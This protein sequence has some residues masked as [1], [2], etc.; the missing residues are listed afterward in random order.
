M[1]QTK[2]T[3]DE[4]DHL[5]KEELLHRMQARYAKH[6]KNCRIHAIV[7]MACLLLLVFLC[8]FGHLMDWELIIIPLMVAASNFMD[9]LWF[10][11]M[12][13]SDDA[14]TMVDLYDKGCK[15]GKV[16]A[17]LALVFVAFFL[18]ELITNTIIEN[19]GVVL[20]VTL[21]VLLAAFA[22]FI[23]NYVFF[24]HSIFKNKAIERLRELDGK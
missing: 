19:M 20:F 18:Y 10:G 16:A 17:L 13:R 14:K 21:I 8:F 12:S 23:V 1:E 3:M 6:A 5:S 24:K 2:L 4:I 7:W 22:F 15:W 9:M 11:K